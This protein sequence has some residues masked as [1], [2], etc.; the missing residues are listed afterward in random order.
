MQEHILQ[1]GHQ[2]AQI[3]RQDRIVVLPAAGHAQHVLVQGFFVLW[4]QLKH[5]A[6][7]RALLARHSSPRH[8]RIRKIG[9]V[10]AVEVRVIQL[11]NTY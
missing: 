8:A 2:H 5:I 4:V 6:V 1:M 10:R 7:E 9:N 3:V 11:L